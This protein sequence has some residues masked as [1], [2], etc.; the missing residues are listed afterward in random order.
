MSLRDEEEGGGEPREGGGDPGSKE[1]D[2]N[3]YMLPRGKEGTLE[4]SQHGES[5]T[6]AV[7]L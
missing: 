1:G 3:S 7:L 5:L 4:I 2:R 6:Q